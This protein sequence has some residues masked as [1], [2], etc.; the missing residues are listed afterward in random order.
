[1]AQVVHHRFTFD[2]YLRIE[3]DSATKHEF[4]DGQV[5]AMAGGSATARLQSSVP[6]M[7]GD[8]LAPA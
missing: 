8:P 1:M 6:Q 2:D 7:T 3:E 5:F 4:V